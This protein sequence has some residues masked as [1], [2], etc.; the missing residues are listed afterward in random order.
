MSSEGRFNYISSAAVT[1]AGLVR[2]HKEDSF[3]ALPERGAF[4]VADGM[5]G[6]QD[7]EVASKMVVDALRQALEDT[8][9]ESPG[10]CKYALQQALHLV[11][12]QV[13]RYAREH[14][15]SAMGSTVVL[16][17][18]NPWDAERAF[19][20]H[21]G[22]SRLYCFHNDELFQVTCD[23]SLGM[24]LRRQDA[25]KAERL[26]PKLA[27]SLTR[28]IG[29][30]AMLAPE[31]QEVAVTAGDFFLLCSD[32]VYGELGE[33]GLEQIFRKLKSPDEIVKSLKDKVLQYGASDNLT[34]VCLEVKAPLP[35]KIQ[36]DSEEQE[37]SDLLLKRAEERIDY[38][39]R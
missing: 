30:S 7:G 10:V 3:L 2:K 23:H 24:E 31:W 15:Y 26:S 4:A 32:G 20:C 39:R 38:A 9:G 36:P 35:D 16:F 37:E 21:V 11:N 22:D 17:M 6:G 34:A 14:Q 33:A 25:E 29:G 28:S 13:C 8:S 18:A 5:G 12:G 19:C 27:R 1:D